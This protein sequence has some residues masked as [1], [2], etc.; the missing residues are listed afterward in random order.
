MYA[1]LGAEEAVADL[2][3]ELEA[4][5]ARGAGAGAPVLTVILDGENPWEHYEG[6]GVPF[7]RIYARKG[8]LPES[9]WAPAAW[10]AIWR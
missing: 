6:D 9:A 2:M 5:Q 1:K 3:G 8:L 7:L 4:W 10:S